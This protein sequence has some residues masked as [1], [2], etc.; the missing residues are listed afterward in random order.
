MSGLFVSFEGVDGVGKTTQVER[1]RAYLESQGRTVVVTRE[2][3]GTALGSAIR[4]LLLHGVPAAAG[5]DDAAADADAAVAAAHPADIAPRA[6]ALLFA[7]DRAQHVAETIRPALERGEVVITDRYLDSS[8]A[9]QAGGRELTAAEI[10]GL[11]LW[12][13]N[14][15]LPARTYLLDMDPA[16][17]HNRLQHAEDRMES[18]G[19]DFQNRTRQAFLDLAAAEPDRFRVID[20]SQS[21]EQ[22]WAAIEADIDA[23]LKETVR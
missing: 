12:A 5:A 20:A 3:G 14:N 9:Y 13:T 7:A 18:A 22:V 23:L 4:G 17:S 8:L 1:L 15:L 10:K 11:S 16:L 21:I 6:E 19:G 2:P